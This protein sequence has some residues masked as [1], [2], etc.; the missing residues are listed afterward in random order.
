LTSAARSAS[1]PARGLPTVAALRKSG[2]PIRKPG[3]KHEVRQVAAALDQHTWFGA[4][5]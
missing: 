3:S 2:D 5:G 1:E 4:N